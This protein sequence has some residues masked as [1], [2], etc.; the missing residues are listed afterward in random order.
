MAAKTTKYFILKEVEIPSA[1]SVVQFETKLP[2]DAKR[3]IGYQIT[4]TNNHS[5]TKALATIGV[6]FNGG[7]ENTIDR[8]LIQ[9]NPSSNVRRRVLPLTQNQFILQNSYVKGYV[10]DHGEADTYPY[11]VKIY[12][13][14]STI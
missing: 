3:V 13:Q 14:L 10:E 8:E 12:F 1:N 2:G 7:R 4:A 5:V 11:D 9:R 6:S